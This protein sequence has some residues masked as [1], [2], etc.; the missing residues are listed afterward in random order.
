LALRSWRRATIDTEAPG[1]KVSATIRRF[2][3]AVQSRR[4]RRPP[5]ATCA[6]SFATNI[7]D[8][9][10]YRF[11]DTIMVSQRNLDCPASTA[12]ADAVLDRLVHNAH[13]L[14][15]KGD[16]MRKVTARRANLDRQENLTHSPMLAT[17]PA[18]FD[19]NRWPLSIGTRGRVQSESPAAIV[20]IRTPTHRQ[21][22]GPCGPR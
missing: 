18:A 3:P 20:G 4:R 21:V 17:T 16:S 8:G 19:R 12:I 15:L 7:N 2:S 10:H 22:T 11:A 9:V 6:A 1:A 5:V 13:R 14:A